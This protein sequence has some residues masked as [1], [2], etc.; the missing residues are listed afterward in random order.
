MDSLPFLMIMPS[1]CLG[2]ARSREGEKKWVEG[3]TRERE[4]GDSKQ[5]RKMSDWLVCRQI[6]QAV[7]T[8]ERKKKEKRG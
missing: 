3:K 4:E 1:L 6:S 2:S 7:K 5:E 8:R